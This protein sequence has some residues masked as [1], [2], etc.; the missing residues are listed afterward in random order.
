MGRISFIFFSYFLRIRVGVS[1]IMHIMPSLYII[2]YAAFHLLY[3][4]SC[5]FSA[6]AENVSLIPASVSFSSLSVFSKVP[7]QVLITDWKNIGI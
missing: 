7:F 1:S 4:N 6:V 5:L 2:T 3:C